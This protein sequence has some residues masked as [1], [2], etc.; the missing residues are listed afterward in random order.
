MHPLLKKIIISFCSFLSVTGYAQA[1]KTL[2]DSVFQKGDVIRT[3]NI[4]FGTSHP[5]GGGYTFDS[6]Q[7]IADFFKRYPEL[8]L[9]VAVH[10]DSR[11]SYEGNFNLSRSRASAI[12]DELVTHFKIDSSQVNYKGYGE[13]KLLISEAQINKAKTKEEQ[14]KL[15]GMNRRVELIVKDIKLPD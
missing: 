13:S 8:K 9:E 4:M 6:I 12:R 2:K 3:T 5:M 15:H 14:N 7:P 11:G 1:N 10:T